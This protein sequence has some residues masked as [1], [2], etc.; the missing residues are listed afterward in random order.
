MKKIFKYTLKALDVQRLYLLTGSKLL[1][2]EEQYGNIVVYALVDDV[3]GGLD[4]FKIFVKRT[5][6]PADDIDDSKFLGT[7]KLG[8]GKLMFH[9]FYR[10]VKK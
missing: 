9:V 2:V 10:Q 7:V 5:G 1:S 6:H 8:E 4:C 3:Q